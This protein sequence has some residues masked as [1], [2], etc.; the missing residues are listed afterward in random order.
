[1]WHDFPG[2][3][4]ERRYD[5]VLSE[6]AE[7]A[8]NQHKV[9]KAEL[10]LQL[11]DARR[12]SIRAAD[13]CDLAEPALGFELLR[14]RDVPL[15]LF[16][17]AAVSGGEFLR[18]RPSGL[19]SLFIRLADYDKSANRYL[20]NIT[21]RILESPYASTDAVNRLLAALK[22]RKTMFAKP[23]RRFHSSSG[24]KIPAG[25]I[26]PMINSAGVTSKPGLRAARVSF[27]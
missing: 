27:A 13:N 24:L 8:G 3:Q 9:A 1:M 4:F 21:A 6:I 7:E 20:R 5:V 18:Y 22:Q 26:I 2:K 12:D 16:A 17:A 25:V 23:R 10:V 11:G 15:H 19:P 14:G